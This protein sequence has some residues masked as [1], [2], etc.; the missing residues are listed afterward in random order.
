VEGSGA[1]CGPGR[2]VHAFTYENTFVGKA[3]EGLHVA[4][5]TVTA[6]LIITIRRD[7]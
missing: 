3:Q 4:H 7:F 5:G 6:G 2:A 1:Q